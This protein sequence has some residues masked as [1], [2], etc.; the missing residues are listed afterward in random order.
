[1]LARLCKGV[2][3]QLGITLQVVLTAIRQ[4]WKVATPIGLLLAALS[5]GLSVYEGTTMVLGLLAGF[6][7]PFAC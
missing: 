2:E 7:V 4:W 5:G 1:M 3:S 6:C